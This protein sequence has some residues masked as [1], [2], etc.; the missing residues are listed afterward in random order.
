MTPPG[1]QPEVHAAPR[2]P[3]GR[4]TGWSASARPAPSSRPVR[5]PRRILGRYPEH[6]S[7]SEL[8]RDSEVCALVTVEE[9]AAGENLE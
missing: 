5:R 4:R 3:V 9:P 2:Q 8:P 7:E 1:P 6:I